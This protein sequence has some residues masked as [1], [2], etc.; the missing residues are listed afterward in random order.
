MV[1]EGKSEVIC[2][3]FYRLNVN[4]PLA[5]QRQCAKALIEAKL[6]AVSTLNGEAVCELELFHFN[7]AIRLTSSF[8]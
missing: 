5:V 2:I 3:V 4:V 7:F 6:K 1:E 8:L